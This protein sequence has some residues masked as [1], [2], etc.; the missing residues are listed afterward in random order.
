MACHEWRL[1]PAQAAGFFELA[2]R[3][4]AP[5]YSGFYFIPC[6]IDG[7]LMQDGKRWKFSIGGAGTAV[8]RAGDVT[9]HWGCS[10]PGCA[11]LLLLPAD[12]MA[13]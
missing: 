7:E 10:A 9:V 5:P 13:P 6:S 2:T 12:G 3:Y 1:S 11:R 8:W 4:A